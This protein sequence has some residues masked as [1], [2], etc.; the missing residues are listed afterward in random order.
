MLISSTEPP[1]LVAC[2][3]SSQL[4]ERYGVDILF[5]HHGGFS[6]VQRKEWKDFLASMSDGRLAEQTS[7][8]QKLTHSMVVIEGWGRFSDDGVLL[9]RFNSRVTL[10]QVRGLLW[11]V[12]ARGHWVDRSEE[13][14]SELQSR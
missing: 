10:A 6:G 14:T 8:M 2:G 11:S 3:T 5:A 7:R 4:P 12:L 13:H 9:D 1:A